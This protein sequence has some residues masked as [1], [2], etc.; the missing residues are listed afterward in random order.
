M[1]TTK[2]VTTKLATLPQLVAMAA[3]LGY[4]KAIAA[5]NPRWQ[6]Y[7]LT[8]AHGQPLT[9]AE[10]YAQANALARKLSGNANLTISGT[11]KLHYAKATGGVA[12]PFGTSYHPRNFANRTKLAGFDLVCN[13]HATRYDKCT[14]ACAIVVRQG[15]K[16]LIDIVRKTRT[17]KA[18]STTTRRKVAKSSDNEL[19]DKVGDATAKRIERI[20][21][22]AAEVETPVI[23]GN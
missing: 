9:H 3:L 17:R 23:A 4:D 2:K 8:V 20:A 14:T 18:K 6:L 16:P 22:A 21:N 15:E 11:P 12:S 19:V 10:A 5:S 13:E 7:S 1:A